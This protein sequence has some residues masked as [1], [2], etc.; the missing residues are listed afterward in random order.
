VPYGIEKGVIIMIGFDIGERKE[1][2]ARLKFTNGI[3]SIEI[4]GHS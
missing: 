3:S 1:G 2:V 4:G